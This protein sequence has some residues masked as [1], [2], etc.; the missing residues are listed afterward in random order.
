MESVEH[1][2]EPDEV[3][4]NIHSPHLMYRKSD[5]TLGVYPSPLPEAFPDIVNNRAQY[6]LTFPVREWNIP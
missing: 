2:L 5:E 4:R 6:V 3:A 1:L